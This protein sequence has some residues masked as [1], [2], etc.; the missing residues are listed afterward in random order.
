MDSTYT[1]GRFRVQGRPLSLAGPGCSAAG[2][3]GEAVEAAR[4]AIGRGDLEAATAI[5]GKAVRGGADHPLLLNL[6]AAELER[7]G[8]LEGALGLL[9]RA[10]WIAPGDASA[11]NALGL[12]LESLGRPEQA[13]GHFD[14]ALASKP[15]FAAGHANRGA[16]LEALGE[17]KAAEAA[18]RCALELAPGQLAALAGLA[19]LAGRFGD[20]A[21]ARELALQV[22]AAGPGYPPA[23]T[24]LASAE[25]ALEAARRAEA[26]LRALL[27]D[28]RPSPLQK[29]DALGRLGDALDA[30]DRFP[31]AF[32][33]YAAAG[34]ERRR[35]HAPRFAGRAGALATAESLARRLDQTPPKAW[36]PTRHI[37]SGRDE[38]AV[39]VFL[40]GFARSA[41]TLLEQVLAGHDEVRALGERETLL[42]ATSAYL[43]GPEGLDRLMAADEGELG[44]WRQAYW[45]RVR[46]AGVD[47]AGAVFVDKH[48]F[49][50]LR[51]PLVAR[52]FPQAR[53]MFAVRDPRDVV[54]SC[55]RRRFN[56]NP[57]TYELLTLEG[58][59]RLYA[60]A[61]GIASRTNELARLRPHLV[62]HEQ[63]TADF[64][65][66]IARVCEFL[67]VGPTAAMADFAGRIRTRGVNTP[68]AAQL[69][70]GL[71]AGAVGQWRR[72]AACLEPVIPILKPWIERF[73]Y[74]ES[75][76]GVL[77]DAEAPEGSASS[78]GR[79]LDG[80]GGRVG[81]SS[82]I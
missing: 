50:S 22:L 73:G 81:R 44:P 61:M 10:V 26:R 3:P 7:A 36:R 8:D 43:G 78:L 4:I 55:L 37:A 58:S 13:L 63:L 57:L 15:E 31:E 70:R 76:C 32:E 68:S 56:L 28:P 77:P 23:V 67:G 80:L 35:L 60:A 24:I 71:D 16:A 40:L 27:A 41:T 1:F 79:A 72:Y 5:A 49:N 14:A 33:A 18:Y 64:G 34:A 17:L 12:C 69:T 48:P 25:I 2:E 42:D 29:A 46:E 54:L 47:P 82:R 21:Q 30:M 11:R 66:E 75:P 59:A 9:Q 51:L 6:A 65:G 45:R 19:S 20:H 39:H 38:P 53:I 62:R 52:L 74:A